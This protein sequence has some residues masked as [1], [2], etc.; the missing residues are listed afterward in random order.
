MVAVVRM[1]M[2]WVEL[3]HNWDCSSV[4]DNLLPV[5]V[6][7]PVVVPVG[8]PT[9]AVVLMAVQDVQHNDHS[10]PCYRMTQ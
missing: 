2:D 6:H 10:H 1:D 9:A 4:V 8:I 3:H 7:N 5:V